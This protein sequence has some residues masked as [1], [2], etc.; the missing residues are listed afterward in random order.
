MKHLKLVTLI[1]LFVIGNSI[2][3]DGLDNNLKKET[4]SVWICVTEGSYAYHF[5][6]DCRGMKQCKGEKRKVTL[7]EAQGKY[8]RKLC[9]YED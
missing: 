1:C 7:E 3:S 9:G 2:A 6:Y 5:D 8:K 4:T